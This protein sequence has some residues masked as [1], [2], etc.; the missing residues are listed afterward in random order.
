MKLRDFSSIVTFTLATATVVLAADNNKTWTDPQ[1]AGKE[2]PD[3]TVQGE[4][5]A[6]GLGAQVI[7]LGDGHF[8]AVLYPGGLPGAGWNGKEKSLLDGNM[9][10]GK[11]KFRPSDGEK[12]YMAGDPARFSA[13]R[14]FPPEGHR[15]YRGQIADS[16]FKLALQDGDFAATLKK[17]ERKSPTLGATAPEGAVVLFDG[18]N[19]RMWKSGKVVDGLLAASGTTSIPTFKDCT[20]HLEFRTPYKPHGRSQ[21]RGNSGV[22]YMGRWETQVLDSFGLEGLNNECGGIYSIAAPKVNM[23][24]PPL[25]WQTYDVE[26]K[27]AKFDPEGNR[28][29]WP[30]IQVKLNGVLVHE[31]LELGKTHTTAAPVHGPLVPETGGPIYLQ[32]HGNPV[33]YRNIWVKEKK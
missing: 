4:Y 1:A 11:A 3:F 31:D 23:C 13:T 5:A 15:P 10:G 24:L 27:S 19:A 21:G 26:Y 2:D 12:S 28:T 30:R 7:A 8:Q 16:V 6:D 20:I 32:A 17:V 9:D 29:A 33:F 18:S 22:Y 14:D 25:S